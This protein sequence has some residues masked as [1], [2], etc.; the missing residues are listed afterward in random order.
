MAHKALIGDAWVKWQALDDKA[1]DAYS[2]GFK[3]FLIQFIDS[4]IAE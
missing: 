3:D 4:F 2:D 1:R